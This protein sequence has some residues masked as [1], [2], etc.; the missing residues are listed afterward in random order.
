[1]TNNADMPRARIIGLEQHLQ[2]LLEQ[3][4]QVLQQPN[5]QATTVN[6]DGVFQP[7][8]RGRLVVSGIRLACSEFCPLFPLSACD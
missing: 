7:E 2:H 1:M 8:F 5:T 6:V 4:A 3:E